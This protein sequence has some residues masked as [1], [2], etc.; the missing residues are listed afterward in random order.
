MSIFTRYDSDEGVLHDN[1][2]L[3]IVYEK[4]DMPANLGRRERN[5]RLAADLALAG[6]LWLRL[7]R[8]ETTG[9]ALFRAARGADA[10]ARDLTAL[11]REGNLDVLDWL[12]ATGVEV[13]RE[14]VTG[15]R[16]ALIDSLLEEYLAE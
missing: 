4:L 10:T 12:D 13:V 5:R 14:A 6:E 16:S 9:Q 8:S 11:A 1:R 3:A 2:N 15:G 7:G